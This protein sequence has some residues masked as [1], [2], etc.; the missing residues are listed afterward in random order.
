MIV[1]SNKGVT[2]LPLILFFH[3]FL[4]CPCYQCRDPL[5]YWKRKWLY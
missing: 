4:R 5:V 2:R 1:I 3:H